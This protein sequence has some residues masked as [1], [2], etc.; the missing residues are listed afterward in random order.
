MTDIAE[1]EVIDIADFA[2]GLSRQLHGRVM[3]SERPDHKMTESWH[4]IGPVGVITPWN[5]PFM[6]STGKIAPALAARPDVRLE[7]FGSGGYAQVRD[8]R[9][10][11][12]TAFGNARL[13]NRYRIEPEP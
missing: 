7:I 8:M 10:A 13:D 1:Q 3:P 11:L 6:L 9:R 2:T 12:V 5:T 4:P